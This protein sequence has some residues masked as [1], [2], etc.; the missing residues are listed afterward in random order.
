MESELE[1][2]KR[3]FFERACGATQQEID[4]ITQLMEIAAP[5]A[6]S[7]PHKGGYPGGRG[8]RRGDRPQPV[9]AA[10]SPCV[11]RARPSTCRMATDCTMTAVARAR[12]ACAAA[13]PMQSRPLGVVAGNTVGH[14]AGPHRVRLRGYTGCERDQPPR[15]SALPLLTRSGHR[16]CIAA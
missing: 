2:A 11:F 7:L 3:A 15:C 5:L 13:T 4:Q 16:V 10:A 6:P 14:S 1:A 9:R 8:R 12:C